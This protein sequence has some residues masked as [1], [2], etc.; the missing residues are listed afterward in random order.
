M[1]LSL[2]STTSNVDN[3]DRNVD[4]VGAMSSKVCENV[5]FFCEECK[6]WKL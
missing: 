1:K 6:L 2:F 3:D 4:S 5:F